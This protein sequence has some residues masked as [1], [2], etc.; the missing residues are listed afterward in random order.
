[1]SYQFG[2]G[3]LYG[4]PINSEMEFGCIQGVSLDYSFDKAQLYCG[5]GLYPSDVRIHTAS[6]TGKAQFA[7]IDAEAINK[8]LGGYNYV[9]GQVVITLKNTTKPS[10]F[11]IRFLTTTD[12]IDII[13]T[14]NSVASDSLSWSFGRTDYIIPDFGFTAYADANGVVGTLDLGDAS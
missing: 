11:R 8:I 2:I 6:V 1:M 10:A 9:A 5:A 13:F 4:G 7:D 12:S 3:T 14:L